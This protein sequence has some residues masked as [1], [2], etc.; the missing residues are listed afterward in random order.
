MAY[1]SIL[2]FSSGLDVDTRQKLVQHIFPIYVFS[3][4]SQ[5]TYAYFH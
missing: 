5:A 3:L 4:E 1:M 2:L